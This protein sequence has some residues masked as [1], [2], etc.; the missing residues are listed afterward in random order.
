MLKCDVNRARDGC[1][2]IHVFSPELPQLN[3]RSN[4]PKYMLR[5]IMKKVLSICLIDRDIHILA[6]PANQRNPWRGQL[7]DSFQEKA[8][9]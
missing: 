5:T 8:E 9:R 2:N 7:P 3:I 6:L 4:V 1:P